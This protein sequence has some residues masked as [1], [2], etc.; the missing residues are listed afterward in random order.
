MQIEVD[1]ETIELILDGLKN[2]IQDINSQNG[3]LRRGYEELRAKYYNLI[4]KII[5]DSSIL[6]FESLEE[7]ASSAIQELIDMNIESKNQTA[8]LVNAIKSFRSEKLTLEEF[9]NILAEASLTNEEEKIIQPDE[10]T[11]ND[12]GTYGGLPS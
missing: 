5:P 3:L 4:D 2:K 11:K 8:K 1:E 12:E 10:S 6:P 7:I 9:E